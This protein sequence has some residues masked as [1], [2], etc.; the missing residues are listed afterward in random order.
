MAVLPISVVLNW[1]EI[2]PAKGV[3]QYEVTLWSVTTEGDGTTGIQRVEIKMVHILQCPDDTL[4]IK[5]Y[6]DPNTNGADVETAVPSGDWTSVHTLVGGAVF[7]FL[8]SQQ[9][10]RNSLGH[11]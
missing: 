3:W 1:V 10:S 8:P 9:S 6:T 7:S 5:T 4:T 11:T 2:L